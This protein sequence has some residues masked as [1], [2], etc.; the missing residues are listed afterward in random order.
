MQRDPE[1]KTVMLC[2]THPLQCTGYARVG[3]AL[4]NGLVQRGWRVVYW[5]F[6]N[7]A[8]TSGRW[9]D[10]RINVL[11]VGQRVQDGWSFGEDQLPEAVAAIRPDVLILYNDVM[12]INRFLD[13]LETPNRAEGDTKRP[14]IVS[15]VD[16]VHDDEHGGLVESI[17]ARSD[18]V[19]VF[20]DHW[21]H[22]FPDAVVVPHGVD[23]N[24]VGA[25]P[26]DVS[27]RDARRALGLPEDAFLVVNTNRNS[28]RKALDLTIDGFLQFQKTH[29]DAVLVLNTNASCESGYDLPDLVKT[30]IRR[31]ALDPEAIASVIGLQGGGFLTDQALR[32]LH[33]ASDVGV[34]TCLGE[35][36]GLC[37]LEGACLGIPQIATKTGGLVDILRDEPHQLLEPKIHL[38]LPRGFV[39]H[40][41]TLDVPDPRDVAE[42]LETLY[43]NNKAA[44]TA[45][46]LCVKFRERYDWDAI[47]D[48]AIDSLGA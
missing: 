38:A 16:L 18:R 23:P 12:V 37:Q 39:L 30:S 20:S 15:Y 6:Q 24:V 5:G 27:K 46:T 4:A 1:D 40:S 45:A 8:A 31:H 3:A 34:N 28:Y 33:L 21:K 2:A 9:I 13:R 19:W 14:K 7:L 11:D 42:A 43:N 47:I 35:G 29:P 41:G 44:E 25:W 22:T 10:P 26:A 36:F 32:L 48:K 17:R